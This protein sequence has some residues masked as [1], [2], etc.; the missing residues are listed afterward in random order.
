MNTDKYRVVIIYV[1]HT[2]GE[3][4]GYYRTIHTKSN[5]TLG[6]QN[7]TFTTSKT[8]NAYGYLIK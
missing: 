7:K 5:R 4:F 1:T 6:I 3:T 8:I 2:F